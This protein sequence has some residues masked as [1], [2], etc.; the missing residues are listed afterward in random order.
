M[1]TALAAAGIVESGKSYPIKTFREITGLG[2]MAMR[3]ARQ[4]GLLVRRVGLR[5]FI[6]GTDWLSFVEE[7]GKVVA[8]DGTTNGS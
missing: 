8:P 6:L 4:K 7:H 3:E 2:T 5:S 1:S